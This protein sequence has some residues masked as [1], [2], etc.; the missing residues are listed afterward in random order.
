M[1]QP[2][3]LDRLVKTLERI[4]I[5]IRRLCTWKVPKIVKITRSFVLVLQETM[6]DVILLPLPPKGVL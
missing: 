2:I 6:R 3:D 5:A 1:T 4:D